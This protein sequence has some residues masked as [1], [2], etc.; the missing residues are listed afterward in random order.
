MVSWP[1]VVSSVLTSREFCVH[2]LGSSATSCRLHSYMLAFLQ[3]LAEARTLVGRLHADIPPT[4]HVVHRTY[5]WTIHDR[6]HFVSMHAGPCKRLRKLERLHEVGASSA[7]ASACGGSNACGLPAIRW[8]RPQRFFALHAC[9]RV[10]LPKRLDR[11]RFRPRL[12]E[13][14]LHI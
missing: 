12:R 11:A 2:E 10:R 9:H 7:L 13:H 14:H 1:L 8:R 6:L 5:M 3:A 4:S